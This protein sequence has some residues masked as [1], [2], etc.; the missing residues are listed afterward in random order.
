MRIAASN[1]LQTAPQYYGVALGDEALPESARKK[2]RA[3]AT[4]RAMRIGS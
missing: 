1:S 3:C 2:Y 4:P